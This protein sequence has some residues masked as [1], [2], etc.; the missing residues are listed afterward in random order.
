MHVAYHN[1]RPSRTC[2]L[3]LPRRNRAEPSRPAE[4]PSVADEEAETSR[5]QTL[6]L[7]GMGRSCSWI[8]DDGEGHGLALLDFGAGRVGRLALLDFGRVPN[9]GFAFFDTG[10]D[11][12][13]GFRPSLKEGWL[14]LYSL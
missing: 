7:A 4:V 13:L 9:A 14:G 12:V 5:G 1:K 11:Y 8:L 6:S 10:L 3:F 2:S